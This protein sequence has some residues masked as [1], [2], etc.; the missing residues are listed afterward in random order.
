MKLTPEIMNEGFDIIERPYPLTNE[1][2]LWSQDINAVSYGIQKTAF[3]GSRIWSYMLSEIQ[4]SMSPNKIRSKL[5]TRKPDNFPCKLCKIY[6]QRID[7]PQVTNQ[8]ILIDTVIYITLFFCLFIFP[9]F[10]KSQFN[11]DLNSLTL[12]AKAVFVVYHI[13]G[14][15]AIFTDQL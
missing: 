5:K 2:R 1:L 11:V 6:L 14:S 8:H 15:F 12:L 3:V 4:Q 9:F 13:L 7:H 10:F